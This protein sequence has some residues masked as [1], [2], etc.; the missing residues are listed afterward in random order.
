MAAKAHRILRRRGGPPETVDDAI[1]TAAERALLRIDSFDSLQGW[2]NWTVK[3]AWH[4]VQ[5]QWKREART[6]V[7]ETAELPAGLDP[8]AVVERQIELAA[9]MRALDILGVDDRRAIMERLE[10]D[11]S[12]QPLSA[13]EKMRRYRARRRLAAIVASWDREVVPRIR[14]HPDRPH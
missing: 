10:E 11:A 3:V 12:S 1:Q 8:A 13:A 4:E 7:E 6:A 14:I 5:A 2:T 9:I